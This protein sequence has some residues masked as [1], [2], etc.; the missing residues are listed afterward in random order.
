MGQF[1]QRGVLPFRGAHLE[2]LT[3]CLDYDPLDIQ[4]DMGAWGSQKASRGTPRPHGGWWWGATAG[5]N[6]ETNPEFQE[7]LPLPLLLVLQK[8]ELL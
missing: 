1:E 3:L 2:N 5:S 8:P 4:I 6:E 7:L